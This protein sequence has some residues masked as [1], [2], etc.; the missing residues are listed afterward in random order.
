MEWKDITNNNKYE[1]KVCYF[2]PPSYSYKTIP[3]F[4]KPPRRLNSICVISTHKFRGS[5]I[6]YSK[7]IVEHTSTGKLHQNI[8][9]NGD[10]TDITGKSGSEM[11]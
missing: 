9:N 7:V 10:P 5:W 8:M 6:S 11:S 2:S 4:Q 1:N 3:L